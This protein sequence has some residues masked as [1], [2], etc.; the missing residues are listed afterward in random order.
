MY[1]TPFCPSPPAHA[2]TDFARASRL[3][4]WAIRSIALPLLV[5]SGCA[6]VGPNFTKPD[7][8]VS[9]SFSGAGASGVGTGKVDTARWWS[10]FRDPTL[11]RLIDYAYRQ[12]LTLKAAGA[13][14]LAERAVLGIAIGGYYPQMQQVNGAI[15]Y[16][17][18]S[19]KDVLSNPLN[20]IGPF[21]RVSFGTQLAWEL[22]FWG[23]FRRGIESADA[24]YLAS[25]ASYDDVLVTLIADVASTYVGVRTLQSQIDIARRNVAT[26]QRGLSIATSQFT[27]GATSKL[28]VHQA[29]NVLG[30]TEAIVP[31]L[32]IELQK[33]IDALA[34]LLGLPTDQVRA[35]LSVTAPIP[36]APLRVS[37][38]IPA[39]LL[40]RRPDIRVA[41]LRAAAQSARIG[42]AKADFYPSISLMGTIGFS[43]ATA[44]GA[45]L[46]DVFTH[47]GLVYAFGPSIQWNFLNYGRIEN[48]VRAQ[49]A[50]FQALL[51]DYKHTVLRA[52]QEVNDG[53]A[54][55]VLSRQQSLS[56][57]RSVRAAAAAVDLAFLQYRE[58]LVDFTTVLTAEQNL[59]T[60]ENSRASATGA[61]AGGLISTYRALGGGWENRPNQDFVDPD[62]RGQMRARTDWGQLLPAS[63]PP[64]QSPVGKRS[65]TLFDVPEPEW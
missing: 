50:E 12:N 3:C 58:G 49:D 65:G 44:N 32:G 48:N 57:G 8:P 19:N 42:I 13:R 63:G 36:V 61:I 51:E 7:A 5:L 10:V 28:D 37:V 18:L 23:K 31:Q 52:Q 25:I 26:Q 45:S 41:E 62:M 14:V 35:I 54:T 6:A 17:R 55:F 21:W 2:A 39:E 29:E 1:S 47:N 64:A 38:G 16:D 20:P 22:D 34:V 15:D 33:G 46:G 9:S 59:L 30:S 11:D 60:A 40:T 53:L 24:T 43:A 56:L 4:C 27:G